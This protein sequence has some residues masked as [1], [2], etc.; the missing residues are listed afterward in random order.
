M[1]GE[2]RQGT[3]GDLTQGTWTHVHF[4]PRAPLVEC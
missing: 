1:G 2:D 4:V 3:F